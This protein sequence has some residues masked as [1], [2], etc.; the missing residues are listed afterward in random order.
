[1]TRILERLDSLPLTRLHLVAAFACALGL[2]GD[3]M[4]MS[5]GNALS[6]VFS[7][8]PYHMD[9]RRLSWLIAAVFAGAVIEIGRAHV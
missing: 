8:A 2:G 4:E 1:M 5:L 7:A 9:A 3:L 6:A